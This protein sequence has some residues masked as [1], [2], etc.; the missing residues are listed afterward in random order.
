[1]GDKKIFIILGAVLAVVVVIFVLSFGARGKKACSGE[2]C[3][4]QAGAVTLTMWTPIGDKESYAPMA[5][6]LKEKYDMVLD[7][8]EKDPNTYEDDLVNDIASGKGPDILMMRN[9]WVPKHYTKLYPMPFSESRY[10]DSVKDYKAL[11]PPVV[12]DE[13][14]GGDKDIYG[15][16]ISSDP[17]VMYVNRDILSSTLSRYRKADINIGTDSEDLLRRYP[18]NWN[19]LQRLVQLV[20]VKNGNNIETAGAA[21]GTENN[22]EYAQDILY[23][24][25]LQNGTQFTTSDGKSATFHLPQ[26]AQN[27]SNVYLGTEALKLYTSFA[28]PSSSVY[29][30]NESMPSAMN[31]FINGKLAVMIDYASRDSYIKQVVPTLGYQIYPL[32]QVRQTTS[33][34]GFMKYWS[35]C[36]NRNSK[37]G[38]ASWTVINSVFFD[39]KYVDRYLQSSQRYPIITRNLQAPKNAN[40]IDGQIYKAKSVYKPD[41]LKYDTYILTMIRDVVR[42]NQPPQ[43]AIEKA[44]SSI[45]TLLR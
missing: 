29:T 23:L 43:T 30:W 5:E 21:L 6:Q 32:P 20:T 19:E 7:I 27:D 41:W 36:V 8:I 25:M 24:M 28:N 34:N 45:T 18:T 15:V 39:E 17:L 31:M 38:A 9:D 14:V 44:A 16:P 12:G 26:T 42:Y 4:K 33:P 35:Y 11:F 2:E 37:Y 40:K 22:I 1:M 10:S 13:M 3:L